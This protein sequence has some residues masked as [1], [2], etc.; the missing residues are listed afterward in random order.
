MLKT[1][2]LI[3]R[4]PLRAAVQCHM[5]DTLS[6][7]PLHR[8]R[9]HQAAASRRPNIRRA[10]CLHR[11]GQQQRSAGCLPSEHAD[12]DDAPNGTA[13]TDG[14]AHSVNFLQK[15]EPHRH[16]LKPLAALLTLKSSV[17]K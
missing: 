5:A 4:G 7:D 6:S 10:G 17:E 2:R 12:H 9:A 11:A 3:I 13:R 8:M 14:R 16:G 15:V 1:L